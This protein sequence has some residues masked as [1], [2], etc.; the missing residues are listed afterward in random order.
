MMQ[1]K[2]PFSY[3]FFAAVAAFC[4]FLLVY[5]LDFNPLGNVSWFWSW[6][7]LTAIVLGMRH[8]RDKANGGYVTYGKALLAGVII[9]LIYSGLYDALVYAFGKFVDPSLINQF[10]LEAEEGM[11]RASDFLSAE[12][13]DMI[14]EEI[15]KISIGNWAWSDFQTKAIS[16]LVISLIAAAFIKKSPP[17]FEQTL[18]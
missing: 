18:N 9:T 16:G 5:L 14:M 15:D 7:I 13:Y 2:I 6:I 1:Y 12:Q 8:F 10:I 4:A 17:L 11:E 3:G